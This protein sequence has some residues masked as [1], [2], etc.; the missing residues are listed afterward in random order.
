MPGWE[1]WIKDTV[2]DLNPS[3]P[4]DLEIA[5]GKVNAVLAKI[6]D[7]ALRETYR[8][9]AAVWLG[10]EPHLLQL[11]AGGA[12]RGPEPRSEPGLGPKPNGKKRVTT[13]RYLLQVLAVRPDAAERVRARLK[14]DELEEDERGA[15][16]R[17]LETL[18]RGGFEALGREVSEYPEEEQD[19]IRQAWHNPPPSVDDALVDELVTRVRHEAAKKRRLAI[20]SGLAEAERRQDRERAAAL[21]AE[22]RELTRR[23]EA[24]GWR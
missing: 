8:G 6:A 21:E 17:M 2:R 10:I 13:A 11:R 12:G 16:V 23:E 1:F 5:L 7:P 9:H 20:I 14:P 24:E 19:L 22:L 4:R 18:Q 15:Y 3:R